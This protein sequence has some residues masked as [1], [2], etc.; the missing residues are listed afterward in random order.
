M[1]RRKLS[2]N[3]SS[4]GRIV[5]FLLYN[6]QGQNLKML[7]LLQSSFVAKNADISIHEPEPLPV[8]YSNDRNHCYDQHFN[9]DFSVSARNDFGKELCI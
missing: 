7:D 5:S 8:N 6:N 9:E 3:A 1:Q 4:E 2:R